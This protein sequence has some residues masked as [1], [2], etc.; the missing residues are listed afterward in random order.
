[1]YSGT[2]VCAGQ[3]HWQ[4]TTLWKV[5]GLRIS[6]GFTAILACW[7]TGRAG[8][9]LLGESRPEGGLAAKGLHFEWIGLVRCSCPYL[10][11]IPAKAGTHFDLDFALSRHSREGGNPVTLLWPSSRRTPGTR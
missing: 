3:A 9:R 4:S 2:G 8:R 7:Q 10:A 5:S 6:V 1:M 11:V